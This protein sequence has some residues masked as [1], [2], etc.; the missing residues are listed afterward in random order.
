MTV[1]CLIG[2]K[3]FR[4]AQRDAIKEIVNRKSVEIPDTFVPAANSIALADAKLMF[5]VT[6]PG[7]YPRLGYW[8]G[9]VHKGVF[10]GCEPRYFLSVRRYGKLWSIERQMGSTDPDEVL[11]FTFG[12][13]PILFDSHDVARRVARQCCEPIL[14][15]EA[16]CVCWIPMTTSSVSVSYEGRSRQANMNSIEFEKYVN[17]LFQAKRRRDWALIPIVGG[18]YSPTEDNVRPLKKFVCAALLAREWFYENGPGDA[19][20]L[21]LSWAERERLKGGGVPHILAWF[22]RSLEARDY[23][24]LEHPPFFD[25]A[26]GVM[27]SPVT[28]DRVKNDPELQKRFPPRVLDGLNSGLVWEPPKPKRSV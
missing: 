1:D 19:Q 3:A 22:A 7:L 14:P 20:P 18:T 25:Y 11:A 13:T 28:L 9:G 23:N 15:E 10:T 5:L 17:R 8:V 26:C 21:P 24:Y 6:P 4:L 12:P 27:A 16:E 2:D